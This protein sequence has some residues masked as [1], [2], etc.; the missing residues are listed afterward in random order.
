MAS[1]QLT[2]REQFEEVPTGEE[3]RLSESSPDADYL[4]LVSLISGFWSEPLPMP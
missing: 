4:D 2:Y 1:R 3:S